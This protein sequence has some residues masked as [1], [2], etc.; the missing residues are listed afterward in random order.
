MY[1]YHH[2]KYHQRI[3]PFH[4]WHIVTKLNCAQIELRLN[5]RTFKLT[6]IRMSHFATILEHQMVVI[7]SPYAFCMPGS[8]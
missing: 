2:Y 6:D 7:D 4:I 1:K 3:F 8:D 5:I